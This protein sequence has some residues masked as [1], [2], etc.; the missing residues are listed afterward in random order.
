M[1]EVA[2]Y[3]ALSALL[4]IS[5]AN[6]ILASTQLHLN[7]FI[8]NASCLALSNLQSASFVRGIFILSIIC[9]NCTRI[10]CLGVSILLLPHMQSSPYSRSQFFLTNFPSLAYFT[11]YSVLVTYLQQLYS[12]YHVSHAAT[13]SEQTSRSSSQTRDY[14]YEPLS[15]SSHIQV[16]PASYYIQWVIFLCVN[17]LVYLCF[18]A[19]WYSSSLEALSIFIEVITGIKVTLSLSLIYAG[20]LIRN[21]LTVAG[22]DNGTVINRMLLLLGFSVFSLFGSIIITIETHFNSFR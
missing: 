1:Y 14:E 3:V 18:I 8:P 22:G 9:A 19:A 5:I 20:V 10:V 2:S 21:F 7:V 17:L 11:V 13:G 4:A 6:C 15:S 16:R 12:S